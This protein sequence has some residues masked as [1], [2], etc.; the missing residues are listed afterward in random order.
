M[1]T[2]SA[3]SGIATGDGAR[4]VAAV[5]R[6]N[7]FYTRQIGVLNER[8]LRS[9]F[10]LTQV[11]VL[12]ELVHRDA[13]AA[14]ELAKALDLDEGYLSRILRGFQ[15]RGLVDS[16]PS[17]RDGRQSLLRLTA[18]GEQAF[19]ALDAHSTEHV[20]AM[21]ARLST[22]EQRCLVEAMRTIEE[23]LGEQAVEPAPF[24]LRPHQ[25]G[26]MGWVVARHG[27][28]Y[29]EEHGFGTEFEALVAEIV[30]QFLRRFDPGRERCWIAERDGENV[31]CIFLLKES[32]KLARL[33]MFLV[34]PRARGLGI[35]KRLV[36][37]CIG[38]ARRVGYHKITLWTENELATARHLYQQAGFRLVGE[39][40]HQ[41]WGRDLMG[42]TWELD[43]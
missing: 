22:P 28:L 37:E 32:E 35:G 15:G 33:R 34:E 39:E 5:R 12:Y 4:R 43:L 3:A 9:P 23:L 14:A 38:F 29:A 11:R 8:L 42:Q 18:L 26:D 7:R 27:A 36:A 6:F 40:R 30:A 31:G 19:A 21:L 17:A 2:A 20:G 24:L 25:P 13:P 10:S 1:T 41:S 16:R